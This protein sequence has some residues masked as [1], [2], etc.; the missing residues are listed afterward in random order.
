MS[1]RQDTRRVL[2]VVHTVASANRLLDLVPI[3]DSDLRVE[4]LFTCPDASAIPTGVDHCFAQLGIL[5]ISWTQA[6]DSKFDLAITANHR[7]DLRKLSA[8]LMIVSHG[9]GYTK[10]SARK[11]ENGKRKTENGNTVYGLTRDWLLHDGEV[12]PDALVLSHR[13]QW[14]R[15]ARDVPEA[16]GTAVL[17]GDPCLDRLR[18]SAFLRERYRERLGVRPH[19]QLVVISSTW[20]S[21]SVFGSWPDLFRQLIAELP[22]DEYRVA[23]ILHPHVWFGHSP[24]Q[25][26]L[27][28]ADCLRAGLLLVPPVEGWG[29]TLVAADVVVGDHGAVTTYA[30]ALDHPVLLAAFPETDVAPGTCVHE[31]GRR[32]PLLDRDRPL[33]PQLDQVIAGFRPGQHRAVAD[34]VTDLPGEAAARHRALA[35]ELLGLAEP[36]EPVLTPPLDPDRLVPDTHGKPGSALAF[37]V[38]GGRRADGV[39]T[40]R[41]HPADVFRA[42]PLAAPRL[43]DQHLVVHT[44]HPDPALRQAAEIVFCHPAELGGG[45]EILLAANP[46]CTMLAELTAE[47]C[48]LHHRDGTRSRLTPE[49]AVDPLVLASAAFLHEQLPAR[50]VVQVAAQ[51]VVVRVTPG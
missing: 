6:L 43:T 38:T 33:R 19:Q 42:R 9:V 13:E 17:A 7:G 40:L 3:F 44:E 18:A 31:L 20:F 50:F 34:L 24:H 47:G 2:F 36:A 21:R 27:W 25:L 14:H 35:Y 28:L 10:N 51:R 12:I 8:P 5:P 46:F 39:V 30:A 48:L 4:L 45:P 32:A 16:L 26:R 37:R 29:A 1:T 22:A 41:R 11:T 15:L 49:A 23:A